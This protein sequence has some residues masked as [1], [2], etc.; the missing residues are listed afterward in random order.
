MHIID[1]Y[2]CESSLISGTEYTDMKVPK[3]TALHLNGM[4]N[5]LLV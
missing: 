1:G 5:A 4:G 2:T 3:Q